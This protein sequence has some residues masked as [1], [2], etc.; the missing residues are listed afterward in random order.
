MKD[1]LR[2]GAKRRFV[3]I[4]SFDPFLNFSNSASVRPRRKPAPQ[5]PA[6]RHSRQ[7]M[8]TAEVHLAR[9][10]LQHAKPECRAADAAAGETEGRSF[11]IAFVKSLVKVFYQLVV[12]PPRALI[13][14]LY[15]F[16]LIVEW[17]V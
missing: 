17:R 7:I 9:Q 6:A 8:K 15:A 11:P 4:Y 12:D 2:F 5:I 3:I 16:I 13:L 1:R 10:P 14:I